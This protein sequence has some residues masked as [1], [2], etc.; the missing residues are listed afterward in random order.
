MRCPH[1]NC[2][3][4]HQSCILST[5]S[6]YRGSRDAGSI[7]TLPLRT[8][9]PDACAR[10]A[11]FTNHCFDKR[12]STVVSQR[13]QCPTACIYGRFSATTRPISFSLATTAIRAAKRSMPSNS[14]PVPSITPCSFMIT[15]K[16]TLWRIAISKSFGSCAA[17]T[18]TA[19]VPKSCST[20]SSAII[21]II[22]FT[23]GRST[24]VPIKCL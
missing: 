13:E 6:K 11:T 2:R 15:T 19:P 24:S 22:R 16:G 23:R 12:G 1:H 10:G 18:F 7:L 5:H 9:S 3:E 8:A 14:V 21:G 4:M 20:N 17:V